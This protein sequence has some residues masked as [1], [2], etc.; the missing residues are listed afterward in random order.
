MVWNT[1]E[2]S[3]TASKFKQLTEWQYHVHIL[4]IAAGLVLLMHIMGVHLF[5]TPWHNFIILVVALEVLDV[6]AHL[7]GDGLGWED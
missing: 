1:K 3:D 7:F 6:G 2:V 4:F 5:H